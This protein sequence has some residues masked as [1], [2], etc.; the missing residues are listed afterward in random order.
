MEPYS[1]DPANVGLLTTPP[2]E[3]SSQT[4]R[5]VAMGLQPAIHAIGDRGNRV[6]LDA[7]AGASADAA[8]PRPRIEHSQVIAPDDIPR[9]GQD[10]VVASV[11]PT[12][13]TSD[14]YWAEGRVGPDRIL[15]GYAWRKLIDTGAE[16]AC[17]SDFPVENANPFHG[18]Y[19]AVARKDQAGWPEEGWYMM[20]ALTREEALACFTVDGARASGLEAEVGS[21]SIG[22][23]ADFLVLDRDYMTVPDEEIW[24]IQ[25]LRTVIGGETVFEASEAELAR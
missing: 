3:L 25:V 13:A 9:F 18:L 15:G 14:M 10:R 2:D 17:G 12:H 6:A 1:D 5:V 7:I 8:T 20:E 22:K 11:Q 19:A 16:L 23:Y 4:A 21:L 24:Q